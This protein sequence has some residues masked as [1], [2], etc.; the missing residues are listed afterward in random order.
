MFSNL[1][2]HGNVPPASKTSTKNTFVTKTYKAMKNSHQK[3]LQLVD[4]SRCG[5][6][7]SIYAMLV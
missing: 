6:L 4:T 7:I 2:L 3:I 5:T 1:I